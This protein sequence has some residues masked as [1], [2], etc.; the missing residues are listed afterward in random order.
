MKKIKEIFDVKVE[1][2]EEATVE[3]EIELS[4]GKGDKVDE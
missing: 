2:D 3:T 1:K 4:D